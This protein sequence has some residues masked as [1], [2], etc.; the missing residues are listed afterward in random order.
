M[1]KRFSA[2]LALTLLAAMAL[3]VATGAYYTKTI[4]F[5]GKGS[6]VIPEAVATPTSTAMGY[7]GADSLIERVRRGRD[8]IIPMHDEI[9]ARHGNRKYETSAGN[10]VSEIKRLV[11]ELTGLNPKQQEYGN[12][13]TTLNSQISMDY[14]SSQTHNTTVIHYQSWINNIGYQATA[15]ANA[16]NNVAEDQYAFLI[17]FDPNKHYESWELSEF[18]TAYNALVTFADLMDKRLGEAQ[19]IYAATVEAL[20]RIDTN[21]TEL[22]R[23][24]DELLAIKA[25]QAATPTPKPITIF[26]LH[27]DINMLIEKERTMVADMVAKATE[28]KG[29]YNSEYYRKS[30]DT[31]KTQISNKTAWNS[32]EVKRAGELITLISSDY[33]VIAYVYNSAFSPTG[34]YAAYVGSSSAA[35]TS[36][37]KNSSKAEELYL[38]LTSYDPY[39]TYTA[40]ELANFKT[41]YNNLVKSVNDLTTYYNN[42]LPRYDA[43]LVAY[44]R[45]IQNYNEVVNIRDTVT[46]PTPAPTTAPAPTPVSTAVPTPIPTQ[47]P[48]A[49]PTPTPTQAPTATPEPTLE[50]TV[51][52]TPEPVEATQEPP[53]VLLQQ[54]AQEQIPV[55]TVESLSVP[56]GGEGLQNPEE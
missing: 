47:A 36:S 28:A 56:L 29:L 15:K 25:A 23:M 42:N 12:V 6:L 48:T 3:S 2:L 34:N 35:I 1:K 11:A 31:L 30:A 22:I 21:Y 8:T 20:D 51:A 13:A 54:A 9:E 32:D 44:E 10:L 50:P 18:T 46:A 4:T 7:P 37:T 55:Q 17:T 19:G 27:P 14:T 33:S 41:A 43:A 24:R 38:Y 16:Y 5:S 40:A 39:K 53:V 26:D 49:T 52:P 45:I